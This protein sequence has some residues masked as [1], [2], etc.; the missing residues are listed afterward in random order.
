VANKRY[1]GVI[2]NLKQPATGRGVSPKPAG[3]QAASMPMRTANWG[4]LPG[5]AGPDR[6]NGV[7]EEKIYACAQ[8][9]RGGKEASDIDD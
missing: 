8:G 1:S 9:L 3:T 5:K 4:G 7:P 2:S 6:S